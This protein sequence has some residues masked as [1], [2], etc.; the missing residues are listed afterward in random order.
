MPVSSVAAATCLVDLP[1]IAWPPGD[2]AERLPPASA[3]C[4]QA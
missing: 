3:D 1:S 4:G 2:L